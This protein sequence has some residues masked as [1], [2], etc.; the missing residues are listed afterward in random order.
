M[1]SMKILFNPSIIEQKLIFKFDKINDWKI[2][3]NLNNC[4]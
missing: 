3:N 1:V 4:W 2:S